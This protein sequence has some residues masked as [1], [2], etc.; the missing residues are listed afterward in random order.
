MRII[1]AVILSFLSLTI[2]GLVAQPQTAQA[3]FDPFGQACKTSGGQGSVCQDQ[4]ENKAQD[5]GGINSIYG[6]GSFLATA[7]TILDI[8]IGIAAVVMIIVG[9]IRF[10]LSGGDSNHTNSAR[11]TVIYAII[12]LVMAVLA[13]TIVVFVLNRV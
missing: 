4:A 5:V 8:I 1:F 6:R 10:V 2:L 9:G 3:A 12:G 13:Q 11:N 7:I